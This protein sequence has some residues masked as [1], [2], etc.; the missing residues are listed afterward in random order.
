MTSTGAP[1]GGKS[2]SQQTRDRGMKKPALKRVIFRAITLIPLFSILALALYFLFLT[3]LPQILYATSIRNIYFDCMEFSSGLYVYKLKPGQCRVKN[4]EY[5]IVLSS[6]ANGFRNGIRASSDYDVAVIGDSFAHGVGVADDQT[7]SSILESNY[8]YQTINLAIG[9]YATMRE[10]EVLGEYGKDAKYVVVQYCDNDYGENLASL[11]LSREDFRSAVEREWR[12]RITTYHEGK[13]LGYRKPIQD[14]AV[15]IG[16]HSYAS[17]SIWR[18]QAKSSR[19]M[20]E[21][22]SAFAQVLARYRPLLEGK[23]VIVFEAAMWGENSP[24]FEATFGSELKKLGWL[25][26]KLL[27]TAD[28]LSYQDYFFLDDHITA[29]GHRKLAAAIAQQISQWKSA[30]PQLN[31]P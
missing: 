29:R 25:N 2:P 1:A 13:S 27:N 20:E 22:A 30:D 5:D 12:G 3:N 24:K 28:V 10:L 23:R 4:L 14:F 9:S 31:K 17:K 6:D 11:K 19:P 7:F 15:M 26:H 8:H 18:N 21:E 16:N